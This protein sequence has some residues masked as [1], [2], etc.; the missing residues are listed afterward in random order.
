MVSMI[1]VK[2]ELAFR[3]AMKVEKAAM[4][5]A[6]NDREEQDEMCDH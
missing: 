3:L 2:A 5:R 1:F 6:R 4:G